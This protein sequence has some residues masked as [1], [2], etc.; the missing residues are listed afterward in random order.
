[1]PRNR[2]GTVALPSE[3]RNSWRRVAGSRRSAP[4]RR[5]PPRAPPQRS[6]AP[7]GPPGGGQRRG[8]GKEE[9]P[10][11]GGPAPP[12]P[13]RPARDAAPADDQLPVAPPSAHP[14]ALQ[15]DIPAL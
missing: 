5:P 13:A 10:G 15:R 2:T 12:P 11:G 7:A 6:R 14:P 3:S 1:M 8:G 9:A 4:P